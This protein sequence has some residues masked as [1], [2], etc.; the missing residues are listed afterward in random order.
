MILRIK[1]IAP[2][3]S[4]YNIIP[5]PLSDWYVKL[6]E[7]IAG[8]NVQIDNVNDLQSQA[9]DIVSKAEALAE[10][11]ETNE[12]NILDLQ[13]RMTDAEGNI[14]NLTVRVGAL[15]TD[16]ANVKLQVQNNRQDI[17]SLISSVNT[18][19]GEIDKINS[20]IETI[21]QTLT[22]HDTRITQ[23]ATDITELKAKDQEHDQE[24][25]ELKDHDTVL[26]GQVKDLQDKDVE[27]DAHLSE[28]DSD[29]TRIDQKD[30]EQDG[31][32]DSLENRADVLETEQA[33][34]EKAIQDNAKNISDNYDAIQEIKTEQ[35]DQNDQLTKHDQR[36]TSLEKRADNTDNEFAELE[37][38]FNNLKAKF[39]ALG[40]DVHDQ[41]DNIRTSVST[42]TSTIASLQ[43]QVTLLNEL[44]QELYR[45]HQE[46]AAWR[47]TVD[48]EIDHLNNDVADLQIEVQKFTA[49]YE[50]L[51]DTVGKEN[52]VWTSTTENPTG[53][54]K[55]AVLPGV[56]TEDVKEVISNYKDDIK[57][58]GTEGQ[59]WTKGQEGN[60]GSWEDAALP[61]VS[62]SDVKTIVDGMK[63]AGH[64]NDI[65]TS[66]VEKATGEWKAP[67][68]T[69]EE[70]TE[71]KGIVSSLKEGTEG[72]V[73]TKGSD[74]TGSWA[75]QNITKEDAEKVT[76]FV[77]GF[78]T[79]GT[80]G[81]VWTKGAEDSGSWKD[82]ALTSQEAS[83][84]KELVTDMSG[85]G[86]EGQVWTKDTDGNGHWADETGGTVIPE[87]TDGQVYTATSDN[88][89]GEWK[90][91]V[92]TEA[93]QND[94]S[95]LVDT[96]KDTGTSDQVWTKGEDGTGSWKDAPALPEFP[97]GNDGELWTSTTEAPKGVWKAPDLTAEQR[98]QL[99]QLLVRLND[100]AGK[101]GFFWT[102]TVAHPDG[103]WVQD[104]SNAVLFTSTEAHPDGEWKKNEPPA[105]VCLA[106]PQNIILP[107]LK[108]NLK[109]HVA[110]NADLKDLVVENILSA[111]L[112]APEGYL[113]L[114]RSGNHISYDYIA[115][116]NSFEYSDLA[117]TFVIRLYIVGIDYRDGSWGFNNEPTSMFPASYNLVRKNFGSNDLEWQLPFNVSPGYQYP[118]AKSYSLENVVITEEGISYDINIK[119]DFDNDFTFWFYD[120]RISCLKRIYYSEDNNDFEV[121]YTNSTYEKV[122]SPDLIFEGRDI[123]FYFEE[124]MP[125]QRNLTLKELTVT[126]E[127]EEA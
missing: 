4:A 90:T 106:S 80:E 109:I 23:N 18:I 48:S 32:L 69:T 62:T 49:L 96:L 54:W 68:L 35:A 14:S 98:A 122:D 102:S 124:D 76:Q 61:G 36:I 55:E 111:H 104:G 34:N 88:P 105:P 118:D 8:L 25:Q 70:A 57:G 73:W 78:E 93:K 74:G 7:I 115:G 24:I 27:H 6:V 107:V 77:D 121:I 65:W 83:Q 64:E 11:V 5:Q 17:D 86:S 99:A 29:I 126:F 71:V 38:K 91:P 42:N 103:E 21:N 51:S 117:E 31:R 41:L 125:L 12:N 101:T 97:D 56:S 47:P 87:G 72:Q 15:E 20:E 81:Q 13:G 82:P 1:N 108:G 33:A 67:A 40:H 89:T 85:T 52:F 116:S 2:L 59:V 28:L 79:G 19:N 66:T 114:Q 46:W 75:D 92:L 95:T 94:V 16:L 127:P 53:E 50:R 10:R 123:S 120:D 22:E 110:F 112:G 3:T 9:D 100:N 84:V 63:E 30:E 45:D 26:D 44:Y 58:T 113:V 60:E 37:S 119:V 39:A 43:S